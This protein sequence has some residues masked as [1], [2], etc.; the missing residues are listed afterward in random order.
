MKNQSNQLEM[1]ENMKEKVF[2][3]ENNWKNQ[4]EQLAINLQKLNC[5]LKNS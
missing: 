2:E 5:N 3:L 4:V 1:V